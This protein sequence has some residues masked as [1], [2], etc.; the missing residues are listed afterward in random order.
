[1]ETEP[2][3]PWWQMTRTPALGFGLGGLWLLLSVYRWWTLDL[4]RGWIEPTTAGVF[5][6]LG[7]VYLASAAATARR[8]A[9]ARRGATARP[10]PGE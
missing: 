5:T 1:V 9:R 3:K 2:K 10:V 6:L 4:D 7:A 8:Q